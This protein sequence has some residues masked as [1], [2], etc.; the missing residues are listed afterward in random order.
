M[1]DPIV[2]VTIGAVV[3]NEATATS[4]VILAVMVLCAAAAVA[5]VFA[6]SKYHP[7]VASPAKTESSAPPRLSMT[8][9]SS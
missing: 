6:L 1:I 7:D 9:G 5:G 3:L 2:A 4:G 8:P